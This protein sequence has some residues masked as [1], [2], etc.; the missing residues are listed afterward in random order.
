M[1]RHRLLARIAG[2]G[3]L[4]LLGLFMAWVTWEGPLP[5]IRVRWPPNLATEAR[6]RAERELD[7]QLVQPTDP[8]TYQYRLWSPSQANIAALVQHPDIDDTA[9]IDTEGF[10]LD[11][12]TVGFAPG[13]AWWGGFFQGRRSA[14]NFRVVFGV[15]LGATLA[16]GLLARRIRP[17]RP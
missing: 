6:E 7:L 11:P 1:H 9:G 8:D 2:I 5:L 17:T 12:E 4:V 14:L 13:R 10:R 3:Q 15:V 16:S